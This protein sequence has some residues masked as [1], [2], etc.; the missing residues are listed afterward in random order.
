MKKYILFIIIVTLLP[1]LIAV[2]EWIVLWLGYNTS[3]EQ[4]WISMIINYILLKII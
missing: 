3:Y 2:M 4:V 1:I